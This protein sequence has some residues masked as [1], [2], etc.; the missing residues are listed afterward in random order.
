MASKSESYE[1]YHKGK[2][3]IEDVIVDVENVFV[4]RDRFAQLKGYKNW[5][6]M[7]YKYKHANNRLEEPPYE[8]RLK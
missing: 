3:I 5:G 4:A 2:S 1:V 7:V 6:Q 8:F